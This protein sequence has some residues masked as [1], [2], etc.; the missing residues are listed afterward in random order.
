MDGSKNDN[1]NV[2]FTEPFE[3]IENNVFTVKMIVWNE[4]G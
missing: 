2:G 3:W 1:C 4:C